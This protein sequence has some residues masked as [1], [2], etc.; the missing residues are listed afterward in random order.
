MDVGVSGGVWGEERGYCQMIG[1]PKN[2]YQYLE[3]VFRALA[4]G[5]KRRQEP[6]EIP[7]MPLQPSKGIFIAALMAQDIL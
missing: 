1:G 2:R 3:P 5:L 4:P 7:G 6:K